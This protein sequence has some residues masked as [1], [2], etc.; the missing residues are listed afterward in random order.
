ML[1][2]GSAKYSPP[3][4]VSVFK[5]VHTYSESTRVECTVFTRHCVLVHRDGHQLK[6]TLSK[7][8]FH[9]LNLQQQKLKILF[10]RPL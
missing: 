8:T 6:N 5:K 10:P 3:P 9:I 7:S 1:K 4:S 2:G